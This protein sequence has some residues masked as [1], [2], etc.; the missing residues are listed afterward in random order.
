MD[1][2]EFERPLEL[3]TVAADRLEERL[4]GGDRY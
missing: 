2:N 3:V 4:F 1:V